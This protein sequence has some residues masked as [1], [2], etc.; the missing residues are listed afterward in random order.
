MFSCLTVPSFL[1]SSRRYLLEAIKN[2][3]CHSEC[4]IDAQFIRFCMYFVCIKRDFDIA[5]PFLSKVLVC[6]GYKLRPLRS[7]KYNILFIILLKSY[8]FKCFS[9]NCDLCSKALVSTYV[10]DNCN[11]HFRIYIYC[12][13]KRVIFSIFCTQLM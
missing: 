10:F 11:Q 5:I 3:E 1:Y 4:T 9:I 7:I 2:V 12:K 8:F 13:S 6:Q